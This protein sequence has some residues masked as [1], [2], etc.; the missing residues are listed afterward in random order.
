[1][2]GQAAAVHEAVFHRLDN[3]FFGPKTPALGHAV[4]AVLQEGEL[5][6]SASNDPAVSFR[7][8][9]GIDGYMHGLHPPD[10][11]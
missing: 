7:Q 6:P 2:C 3:P 11:G 1:M 10:F 9:L 4:D 8:V 5:G